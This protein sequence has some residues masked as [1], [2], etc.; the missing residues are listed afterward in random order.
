MIFYEIFQVSFYQNFSWEKSVRLLFKVQRRL[1]KV[2]YIHDKKN[3]YELQKLIFQSNCARL[4]AIREV[5]Q[6]S[7]NKKIS[8]V[9]GKTTLNFLE[10]FELNEYLRRN[11]NN[12]KPQSL[13]KRC[14][15]DLNENLISETISTISD[16]SWQVLIKF[17]LEPVHEAFF[18]PFNFGFRYNVPIYKVQ[19][20]ILLNLSNISFSSKKRILK[21]ELNCNFSIFNYDYLMKKLIAPRN[22]KLG[23]FRLLELG[24]NLHFPENECQISTFSSLLLNVML[25]GVENVHNCVRYGYYMLFFLR[26]MDNE[27]ILANQILSLLYTRGIKKN[28]SKFLLVSNTKG[29]DFLGWHFKFSEKVKNGISAIPSLNNYQFFLNRVKRI[30]NNSNYGSVVKASKLYPVIKNWREYHKYSDLRSLSYSLFFVKK[31]AFS[32]FN[33]ESKQDFYSSK[34]LLFKSFLVSESFNTVSKKYNFHILNCFSF[35]HLTFLSESSN[36]F[37][38]INLYFCVHCGMKC[39]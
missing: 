32:A 1:F 35:G 28:S 14:V 11:W 18:H 20:A 26:P 22:I 30:V 3:L 8:G 10:R 37:N 31:H 38:K 21:V 6:L 16:R 23:I 12:W 39:I 29:F 36:F 17:A 33:S 2:S 4:L 25:N 27:K 7:F 5:T 15:F 13:R 19:Q 34:R 9:D 24:F